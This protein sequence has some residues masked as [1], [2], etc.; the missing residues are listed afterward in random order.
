LVARF[1]VVAWA[2][3]R[4]PPADDGT[5]Y[6]TLARRLASGAGYTWLWPDGAVTAAAHYPVGYPAV[7]GLAYRLFGGSPTVA[8]I[9]NALVGGAG[10][11]ATVTLGAELRR[12][13]GDG[14]GAWLPLV[15]GLVVA[16]HVALVPY[17][18]A[19]MTEGFTA[20]ILLAA[21]ACA[22]RARSA[23]RAWPW[24]LAAGVVMGVATLVRPQS[25]ALAPVLG[26]LAVGADG[27]VVGGAPAARTRL[28]RAAAVLGIALACVAPWTAR[29]CARMHSCALVSVNGGWNLLIGAQTHTGAYEELKVP[30]ECRTVWDEAA[31]DACFGRAARATIRAA[32]LSWLTRVPAKLAATFDYF[33]AAPW[34]LHD[35]NGAAFDAD[36][37]LRLGAAETL[38]CR[39]ALLGAL[40]AAAR[41]PGARVAWRYGVA[42]VGAL[43][44]LTLHAWIGYVALVLCVGLLGRSAWGRAPLLLPWTAATIAATAAVHA[45]FFGAGRYGLVVVPFV[46]ALAC[47]APLRSSAP[48]STLSLVDAARV[49]A[50]RAPRREESPS[51]TEHDAG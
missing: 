17:T 9:A 38:F 12:A 49:I 34:Y 5:Y 26:A 27:A 51:S 20:S 2:H 28:A 30:P 32:P 33:G 1:G 7:L 23:S 47:A 29:N 39:L 50:G 18:A 25:L 14:D 10:A 31:K 44:A 48:R 41:W 15:A 35:S 13:R 8:M 40:V 22:S 4:F 36:A 3:G 6:D 45:A 16:L 43:G 11:C 37:K 21:A 42:S 46:A 19:L 24:I